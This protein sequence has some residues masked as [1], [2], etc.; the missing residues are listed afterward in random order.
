MELQLA[1]IQSLGW[2]V[3]AL[4]FNSGA[5]AER[6][7]VANIP[8]TVVSEKAGIV[9]LLSTALSAA[10]EFKPEILVS[11]GYK[12]AV[13]GAYIAWRLSVPL[14]TTYHGFTEN[15]KGSAKLKA[16]FY[17]TLHR[18][19]SKYFAAR[20]VTVSNAL[21]TALSY[22]ELK[23]LRIVHNVADATAPAQREADQ[24]LSKRPAIVFVGRLVPVKRVDLIL[25]AADALQKSSDNFHIYIVGDGPQAAMLKSKNKEFGLDERV[26]FLGFR[27]DARE[28]IY[29]ADLLVISSDSEGIPTVL[30][31]A[32]F[33]GVPVVST[34]LP[35]VREVLQQVVNYPAELV[36]TGDYQAL[37]QALRQ[38]IKGVAANTGERGS[39]RGIMTQ[40][41]AP[42][43]GGKKHILIYSEILGT[44]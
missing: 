40:H 5:V 19:I 23:K 3:R 34:D 29:A 15:P 11:H 42:E 25:E 43:V 24:L 17:N 28:L 41:F 14:V 1:A 16:L 39:W 37:A 27:D 26:T 8:T 18:F 21:A 38:G 33:A 44:T 6:Y 9:T 12:E 32:M 4:L 22:T 30:L 13:V 35:G 31:D 2:E 10:R 20:V 36:A 7:A